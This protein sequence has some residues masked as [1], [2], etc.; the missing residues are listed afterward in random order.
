MLLENARIVSVAAGNP[1][2]LSVELTLDQTG[3]TQKPAAHAAKKAVIK[4]PGVGGTGR[5][6]RRGAV[7]W[8]R[9]ERSCAGG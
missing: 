7:T 3:S 4:Y 2:A 8:R 6:R 5:W 1:R 9:A